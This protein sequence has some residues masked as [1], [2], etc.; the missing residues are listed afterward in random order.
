MSPRT[1]GGGY[2]QGA[3]GTPSAGGAVGPP[4]GGSGAGATGA[5]TG[6]ASGNYVTV[7]VPSGLRYV[8][9]YPPPPPAPS[10]PVNQTPPPPGA[11]AAYTRDPYRNATPNVGIRSTRST[12]GNYLPPNTY[13]HIYIHTYIF[14]YM[15]V[16]QNT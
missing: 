12:S 1:V 9:P 10:A 2:V 14:I 5:A 8:H 7:P 11:T 16:T 15:Y 6:T 4:G 3:P 13:I